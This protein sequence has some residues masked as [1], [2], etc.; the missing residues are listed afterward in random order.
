MSLHLHRDVEN[1]QGL[2][3]S[4]SALV[5]DMIDR[6]TRVLCE[7]RFDDAADVIAADSA[8]DA[9]EVA[10]EEE[11]LKILALHQPVA[12]DLR[13]ITSIMKINNDL[14]RIAD[15]AVNIADRARCLA[16]Y[17]AFVVPDRVEQMVDLTTQMVRGVL[18][19]FVHLDVAAS[20]RIIRIDDQVDTLNREVIQELQAGMHE[21]PHSI[22]PALHCFSA[23]RHVE[24]IA[25]HAVNIAED[26]IYLVEGEIIR[27]RY[28]SEQL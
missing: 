28:E 3:L 4:M 12:S 24:R 20:R 17:P 7:R 16:E 8:V 26:V 2:V 14:E 13:R 23:V 10:I 15:L 27:H 9:R 11:C 22:E 19:A 5:E 21:N 18:N 6:A 25:D 1:L